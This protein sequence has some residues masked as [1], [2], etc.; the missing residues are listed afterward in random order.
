VRERL[1]GSLQPPH[2]RARR[3]THPTGARKSPGANCKP[4]WK[5][6]L[7]NAFSDGGAFHVKVVFPDERPQPLTD[8]PRPV[9]KP[10]E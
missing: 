2:A 3:G 5:K 6:W 7:A 1:Q 8:G 9:P 10:A 4:S